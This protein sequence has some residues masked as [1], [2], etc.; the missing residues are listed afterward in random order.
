MNRAKKYTN[1][2]EITLA[3]TIIDL[4]ADQTFRERLKK[5]MLKSLMI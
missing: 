3:D 4:F 5:D 1:K 2:E